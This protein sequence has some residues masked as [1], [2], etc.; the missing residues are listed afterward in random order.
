MTPPTSPHHLPSTYL[1]PRITKD[2]PNGRCPVFIGLRRVFAFDP[3]GHTLLE[4]SS[5]PFRVPSI[6]HGLTLDGDLQMP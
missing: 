4:T 6:L 2:Q 5:V 3:V 1:S